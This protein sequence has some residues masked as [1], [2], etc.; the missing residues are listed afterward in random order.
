MKKKI[1]VAL[2]GA[3]VITAVAGGYF[4][5]WKNIRLT[6]PNKWDIAKIS[7]PADFAVTETAEQKII[8]NKSAGLTF[9]VPKDWIASSTE[10]YF[11]LFSAD[12]K[13][14]NEIFMD[15][16]CR[17]MIEIT[18]INT[19]LDILAEN[20]KNGIWG[21]YIIQQDRIRVD[22]KN[23]LFSVVE[24]EK[25]KSYHSEIAIPY[26]KKIYY[27][28]MDANIKDKSLCSQNFQDILDSV[29]IQ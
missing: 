20:M 29:K 19:N 8:E 21:K 9:T 5:W 11:K 14:K 17:I 13:E 18:E 16:G 6:P 1:I 2:V 25:I 10:Y 27:I 15:N 26:Q 12:A 23:A 24:S 22:N 3:V 28:A 7:K 4:W